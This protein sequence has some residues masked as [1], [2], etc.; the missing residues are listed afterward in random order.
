V[1]KPLRTEAVDSSDGEA[2]ASN[3]PHVI[4]FTRYWQ[5]RYWPVWLFL[6]WLRCTAAL[7]WRVAIKL[8]KLLGRAGA[9]LSSRRRIVRRNLEICFPELNA[10]ELNALTTRAFENVSAFIAEIA[11]AWFRSDFVRL[12]RIEGIEHLQ[13]AL[14]KGKGVLLFSGHFTTLEICVP[15]LKTLVPFL[16]FMFRERRNALMNAIQAR[17]RLRTAHEA[18][19]N[20]DIRVVLRML[21]R[22][23]VVWYAPDEARVDSGELLPFFGEPAMTSTAPSRLAKL[24]GA[25]IVPL[26]SRRLADDSGYVLRFHA[27][28]D[29]LP[30]EDATRDTLRLV[31]VLEEFVRECPEQYL[32]T[33]RRFKDRPELPD[34]YQRP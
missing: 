17:G 7:P 26:F 11:I 15:A 18:L 1:R 34:A 8:H 13:A 28:L 12:F 32:W 9:L 31:R 25:T 19:I 16:A 2:L 4:S 5:P 23:A 3:D 30:S 6:V 33:Q 20:N 21:R 24:S 27:P 14:A 22:N 10:R 29:D